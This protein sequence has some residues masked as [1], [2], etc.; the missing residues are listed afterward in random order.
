MYFISLHVHTKAAQT[1]HSNSVVACTRSQDLPSSKHCQ[2]MW[3][4]WF[5][6]GLLTSVASIIRPFNTRGLLCWLS[7]TKCHLARPPPPQRHN[8]VM[9]SKYSLD[10]PPK[11]RIW[12]NGLMAS[13]KKVTFCF[14]YVQPRAFLVVT[15][16]QPYRCNGCSGEGFHTTSMSVGCG[17]WQ[18]TTPR[19]WGWQYQDLSFDLAIVQDEVYA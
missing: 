1:S 13:G 17:C 9:V 4:A 15:L 7:R 18:G 6:T 3:F 11:W 16:W 19:A 14:A 8:D 10:K 12:G 5:W 2:I